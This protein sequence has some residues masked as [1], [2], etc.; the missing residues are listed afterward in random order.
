[1]YRLTKALVILIGCLIVVPWAHA[2]SQPPGHFAYITNYG[3]NT[4]SFID[5]D[6]RTVTRTVAVGTNPRGAAVGASG[7]SLYVVNEG[8]TISVLSTTSGSVYATITTGGTPKGIVVN[9]DETFAYVADYT[10]NKVHIIDIITKTVVKSVTVG[11]NPS[12]IGIDPMGEYVYVA[13]RTGNSISILTSSGLIAGTVA[14]GAGPY[15]VTVHPSGSTIWVTNEN[16]D[17][18]SVINRHNWSITTIPVG[19]GPRGICFNRS[20]TYAYVA[21]NT[22]D[23]VSVIKV[24]TKTVVATI[25]VGNGPRAVCVDRSDRYLYVTNYLGNSVSVIDTTTNSVID[26]VSVGVGPSSMG[27][28]INASSLW[29]STVSTPLRATYLEEDAKDNVKSKN[30]TQTIEGTCHLYATYR[31]PVSLYCTFTNGTSFYL[32]K[33]SHLSTENPKS[34]T[35]QVTM[36]GSGTGGVWLPTDRY[37]PGFASFEGKGTLKKGSVGGEVTSIV[38]TGKITIH[39]DT[40]VVATGTLRF[41]FSKL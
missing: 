29:I 35:E 25:S 18:V 30:A 1:M 4:V 36:N 34:K 14:V 5:T 32:N 38:L 2:I 21:N 28:F 41:G 40:G 13:N 10:A 12:G 11:A 26:T 17:S 6:T 27:Q 37:Y 7:F 33:M 24:A 16:Q 3:T 39:A 31:K 15:D 9:D 22:A 19:D 8:G 20:G 23:A